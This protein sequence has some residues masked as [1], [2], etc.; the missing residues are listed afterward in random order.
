MFIRIEITDEN[1]DPYI[2]RSPIFDNDVQV[3]L[4]SVDNLID[5]NVS[6]YEI[7]ENTEWKF[8]IILGTW[9][10]LRMLMRSEY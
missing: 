5:Y 6:T 9:F 1:D 4:S 10:E 3:V 8:S 7:D 2:Q